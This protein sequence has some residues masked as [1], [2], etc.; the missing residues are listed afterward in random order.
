MAKLQ[1]NFFIVIHHF[2]R[3]KATMNA[4]R[5]C[6]LCNSVNKSPIFFIFKLQA[7][8]RQLRTCQ[9]RRGRVLKPR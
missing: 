9:F 4:P 5:I 8:Q 7:E 6:K 3:V 1:I 2:S